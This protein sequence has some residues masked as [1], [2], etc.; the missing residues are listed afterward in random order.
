MH[1]Q[2]GAINVT[3]KW[4]FLDIHVTNSNGVDFPKISASIKGMVNWY[5]IDL[6]W[7]RCVI[8]FLLLKRGNFK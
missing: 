8:Y 5:T 7:K 3:I 1:L 4:T 2:S 6:N